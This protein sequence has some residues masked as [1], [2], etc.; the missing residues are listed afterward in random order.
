[1]QFTMTFVIY[2]FISGATT[3]KYF[4]RKLQNDK[5]PWYCKKCIKI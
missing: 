3:S 5:E 2:G 4:S 1:M